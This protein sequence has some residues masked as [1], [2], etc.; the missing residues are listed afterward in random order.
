MGDTAQKAD[1]PAG[2]RRTRHNLAS[3]KLFGIAVLTALTVASLVNIRSPTTTDSGEKIKS[4]GKTIDGTKLYGILTFQDFCLSQRPE[5]TEF[6]VLLVIGTIKYRLYLPPSSS[7][8]LTAW[9]IMRQDR[10]EMTLRS[11]APAWLLRL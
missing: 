5:F 7:A 10:L 8:H 6:R 3:G 11:I 1:L 2:N 9:P 4:L